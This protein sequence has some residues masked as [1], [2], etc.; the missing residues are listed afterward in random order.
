MWTK[1]SERNLLPLSSAYMVVACSTHEREDKCIHNF[2]KE[3]LKERDH[4]GVLGIDR[5]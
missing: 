2:S 4:W 5:K 1:V 3:N